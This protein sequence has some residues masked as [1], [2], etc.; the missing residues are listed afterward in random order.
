MDRDPYRG[1][2]GI[3]GYRKDGES[4]PLPADLEER[5]TLVLSLFEDWARKYDF[6]YGNIFNMESESKRRYD[7]DGFEFRLIAETKE[8]LNEAI[9]NFPFDRLQLEP[10]MTWRRKQAEPIP[11]PKPIFKA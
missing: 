1:H 7:F 11:V 6:H 3:I 2:I 9:D 10:L 4:F 8:A 5:R